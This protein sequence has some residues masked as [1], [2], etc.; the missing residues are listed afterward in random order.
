MIIK[1]IFA[2]QLI[3]VQTKKIKFMKKLFFT[4][5]AILMISSL[6]A[7]TKEEVDLLQAAFG[8]EKK[9]IV[10][11]FVQPSAANQEVFWQLY[12]EY[13]TARKELGVTRINLLKQYAENY[14]SMTNETAEAWVSE[15]M[16]LQSATDKLMASYY[17]KIKKATDAITAFKFYHIESYLLSSIR[18]SI[19]EDIPFVKSK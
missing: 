7:Q 11:D 19:L 2:L 4:L 1:H 16:K 13:E 10:A 12:D 18:A 3:M 5:A 17:K 6:N 15:V 9:A 14:S 8:M